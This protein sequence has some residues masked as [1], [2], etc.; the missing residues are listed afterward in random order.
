MLD[1]L[2]VIQQRNIPETLMLEHVIEMYEH[3][4]P[5]RYRNIDALKNATLNFTMFF[6][7]YRGFSQEERHFINRVVDLCCD[8]HEYNTFQKRYKRYLNQPTR[9]QTYG[10]I[11]CFIFAHLFNIAYYFV[12]AT[13]LSV[14]H[15][16]S[17][18]SWVYMVYIGFKGVLNVYD[19]T[20]WEEKI[21]GKKLVCF[22]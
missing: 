4:F 21:P 1:I 14:L 11:I 17:F 20:P 22:A 15:V 19:L 2:K 5:Y 10:A 16:I 6:N 8:K 13:G 9:K 18:A 12:G 3:A 7:V